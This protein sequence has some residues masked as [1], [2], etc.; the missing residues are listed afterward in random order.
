MRQF[1]IFSAIIVLFAACKDE[2]PGKL[3]DAFVLSL[4][5]NDFDLLKNFLPDRAFYKSQIAKGTES[6]AEI[7]DIVAQKNDELMVAWQNALYNVAAKKIDLS[8][9]MIKEVIY[10]DPFLKDTVSEAMTIN[11]EYKGSTWD[12]IQFIVS[13]K[14]GKT[15][16]LGVPTATR[17][18]SMIDR[19]RRASQEA[20]T[21]IELAKPEFKKRIGGL[22]DSL[23]AAVRSNNLEKFGRHL[24]YRGGDERKQWRT[25][26]NMSDSMERRQATEFMR[27]LKANLDN[28]DQYQ[29]G[30]VVTN[31][32]PGGLLITWP[33]DCSNAIITLSFMDINGELLLGETSMEVKPGHANQA[34]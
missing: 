2:A 24:L 15:I 9:V 22:A 27:R 3:E 12:D 7:K 20:R 5:K 18:F 34:P 21:W 16:L 10:H 33:L 26:L 23:I 13:R 6:D 32:Q 28:C 25:A 4:E 1:L 14:T 8:K 31:R 19:D 11:Y 29:T 17:A 30:N